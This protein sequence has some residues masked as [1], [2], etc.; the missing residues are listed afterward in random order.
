[1][2][3]PSFTCNDLLVTVY[4]QWFT[5]NAYFHWIEILITYETS[6]ENPKLMVKNVWKWNENWL[7]YNRIASNIF[8]MLK[9][10]LQAIASNSNVQSQVNRK[11][12]TYNVCPGLRA[13]LMFSP[14]RHALGR[15]LGRSHIFYAHCP[16]VIPSRRW[17]KRNFERTLLLSQSESN[18]SL[19]SLYRIDWKRSFRS[20]R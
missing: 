16:Q 14:P 2:W 9:L 10:L 15:S 5:C 20:I 6:S 3:L 8:S 7:R 13:P 4:L 11:S 1:M 17:Y 12:I 18:R 19:P